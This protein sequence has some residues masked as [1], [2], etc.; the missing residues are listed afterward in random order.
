MAVQHVWIAGTEVYLHLCTPKTTTIS[1]I[2]FNTYC[3]V[4]R[5]YLVCKHAATIAE[6]KLHEIH[7]SSLD[8]YLR[9]VRINQAMQTYS[10]ELR[11]CKEEWTKLQEIGDQIGV[12]YESCH[13]DV[14]LYKTK[15]EAN[16]DTSIYRSVLCSDM[17]YQAGWHID[18]HTIYAPNYAIYIDWDNLTLV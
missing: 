8:T 13:A 10:D 9:I 12:P 2:P 14:K 18:E 5:D 3:V 4:L 11:R 15:P 1:N 16:S 17:T 6:R 7:M